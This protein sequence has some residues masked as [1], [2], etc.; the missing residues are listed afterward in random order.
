MKAMLDEMRTERYAGT[1]LAAP[2][3]L[4]WPHHG[5]PSRAVLWPCEPHGGPK[6]PTRPL[7]AVARPRPLHAE[8]KPTGR[9][10]TIF[11]KYGG[12]GAWPISLARKDPSGSHHRGHA[13]AE[14]QTPTLG[15]VDE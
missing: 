8:M 9:A 3:G 14:G 11:A 4:V 1:A 6:A 7:R 13:H 15:Q 12:E 5:Q 10:L 2:L